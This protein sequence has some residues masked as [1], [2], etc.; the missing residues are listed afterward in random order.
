M[1]LAYP[2]TGPAGPSRAMAHGWHSA[3]RKQTGLVATLR[4]ARPQASFF[5]EEGS[6]A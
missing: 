6:L 2:G 3:F 5:L 4:A 1:S